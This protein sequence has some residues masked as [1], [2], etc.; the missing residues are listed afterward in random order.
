MP[1]VNNP[2]LGPGQIA[3]L[4]SVVVVPAAS[5]ITLNA[6]PVVVVPAPDANHFIAVLNVVQLYNFN[7]QAFTT[8][9]ADTM[10]MKF[11]GLS[12]IKVVAD[13]TAFI[14][15][16]LGG[17]FTVKAALQSGG[18][19]VPSEV[20]GQAINLSAA[21][22]YNFGPINAIAVNTPGT[23][24]AVNDTGTINGGTGDATYQVISIGAGGA[25]TG[26]SVL[27]SGTRYATATAVTTTDGGS[28]PG[29]GTGLKV[30]INSVFT[31]DGSLKIITYY[32]LILVP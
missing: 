32:T 21:S 2:G 19:D 5:I 14:T 6:T 15:A 27:S 7:S 31:G 29:V 3:P 10:S 9:G 28:Q 20:V 13:N 23:G 18:G 12:A 22:S 25:V 1:D 26:I 11:A 16:P 4:Q 24:Y 8:S 17:A 30:N